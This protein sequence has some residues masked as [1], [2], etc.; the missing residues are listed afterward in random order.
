MSL[1]QV[2]VFRYI[3]VILMAIF[4]AYA[5]M[6]THNVW[7]PVLIHAVNNG[8]AGGGLAG[9]GAEVET[10]TWM[11]LGLIVLSRMALFLPFLLTKEFRKP[12]REEKAKN[13]VR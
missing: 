8:L 13:D 6:K 4:M 3:I 12:N 9:G 11:M 5:Y 1:A 7:L 2:I 10:V